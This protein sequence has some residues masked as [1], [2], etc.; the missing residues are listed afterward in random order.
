M[1]RAQKIEA[2]TRVCVAA[3]PARPQLRSLVRLRDIVV[4]FRRQRQHYTIG[5]QGYFVAPQSLT[6]THARWNALQN[7]LTRQ[8]DACVDFLYRVLC[9]GD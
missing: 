8:D 7:D 9:G 6:A 3:Q 5:A 2:I 4:A 1:D